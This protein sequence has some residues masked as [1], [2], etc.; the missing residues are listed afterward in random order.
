MSSL[1]ASLPVNGAL[2]G[3]QAAAVAP[4]EGGAQD[5]ATRVHAPQRDAHDAVTPQQQRF[6]RAADGIHRFFAV[7]L[8]NDVAAADDLM[9][10]L[11][12]H[13]AGSGRHVPEGQYEFWLR[14]IAHNLLRSRWR[15]LRRRPPE[16]P[17]ADA[18]V[19]A[20]LALRLTTEDVPPAVLQR[21]EL[22]DQLLL[23]LTELTSD[24]QALLIAHYFEGRAQA[25]LAES[26]GCSPR[27]VEGRLYRARSALREK[28]EHMR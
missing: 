7:R 10:Q 12:L 23:A 16:V 3:P 27:A 2:S 13:A 17:L 22:R 26:L 5:D 18:A 9:Q 8:G 20:E 11:W 6:L 15:A 24:D 14:R 1:A 28:L 21:K 19:A 25:D 4:A